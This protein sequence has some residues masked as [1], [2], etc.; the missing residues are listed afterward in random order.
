[1]FPP[2][3]VKFSETSASAQPLTK[4]NKST[5]AAQSPSKLRPPTTIKPQKESNDCKPQ[6]TPQKVEI[7][8]VGQLRHEDPWLFYCPMIY[9]D[10]AGDVLGAYSLQNRSVVRLVVR[11]SARLTKDWICDLL[12]IRHKHIVSLCE[13]FQNASIYLVYE[14][15][16]ISL[17]FVIA[18]DLKLREPQI[19]KICAEVGIFI[20][21]YD[22]PANEVKLLKAIRHLK[23]KGLVHSN[24]ISSNVFFTN[25]GETKLGKTL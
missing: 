19:A 5:L 18:C 6:K 15:M 12:Q 21:M 4:T 16:Y 20:Y 13:A 23:S 3:D 17:E 10:E 8:S 2:M 11:R 7:R 14:M 25:G 1:M 22:I 24:I 9:M